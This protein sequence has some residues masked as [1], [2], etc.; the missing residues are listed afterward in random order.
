MDIEDIQSPRDYLI[1]SKTQVHP[2]SPA[3]GKLL[4]LSAAYVQDAE[5]AYA[6]GQINAVWSRATGWEIPLAYASG[7]I[8]VAYSEMGRLSD[9]ES[10]TIAEDYYQFPQETCS[11]VKCTVG[12]WHKR[13]GA[14]IKRIIGASVACE[15]YN[16]AWELMKKE[17]Y[18][19]HAI[20]VVYRAPGVK[21][22]RLEQLVQFL[23]E[24]IYETAEWLTGSREINE[25]KLR[26][27][28]QRKNRLI[29]KVR[30]ILELR[31]KNPYYMRSLPSIY[32]LTGLNT[33]FGKP[34]AYEAVLDELIAE[35]ETAPVSKSELA[36]VI[37]LVWVGSAGQEFGIYEAIDQAGGALL[38]FR[39]YPFNNYD[40]TLPPVEAL[41]RHVLGNQEAGASIYVQ[42]V[43][44]QEL[45]KVKA[46]G[47]V[48]YGYLGCSYGSVA[49]EMWRDYFHKKGF[50]SI[51]LEGTFQVGPPT[52]QILTRIRAFV[53]MLA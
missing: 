38:G 16:L 10:V 37:P 39:G 30:K 20:D 4:D 9:M 3:I 46:R 12:Q 2:Y 19:V 11:M 5:Q 35:L 28:I 50:P 25:E 17:G 45:K 44:E 42:K 1:Y 13:R 40:E 32:L 22:E 31:I 52:G 29:V 6:Q 51:N 21:G 15:P 53:E 48:L 7:I 8:P 36:K 41:A 24:Q 26:T 43:I 27:E 14:G 49:R 47:L 34:A 33:Y 23:I 18:D